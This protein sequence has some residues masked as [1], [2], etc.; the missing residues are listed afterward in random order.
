M[1]NWQL[2]PGIMAKGKPQFKIYGKVTAQL[3]AIVRNCSQGQKC[4]VRRGTSNPLGQLSKSGR[5]VWPHWAISGCME[6]IEFNTF[7]STEG[8]HLG[9]NAVVLETM[10]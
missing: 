4:L 9:G 1:T 6:K 10:C 8:L 5:D 3:Q 7:I 2:F